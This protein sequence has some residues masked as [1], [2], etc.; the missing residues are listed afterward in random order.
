[1]ISRGEKSSFFRRCRKML[2]HLDGT[3]T[4]FQYPQ[5][6]RDTQNEDFA[7]GCWILPCPLPSLR[8]RGLR[9]SCR[10]GRGLFFGRRSSFG[11]SASSCCKAAVV[12]GLELMGP[13]IYPGPCTA[14]L[15][16]AARR[17]SFC[18]DVV[19]SHHSF[20]SSREWYYHVQILAQ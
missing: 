12:S 2:E 15:T 16:T 20:V 5:T 14:I 6:L 3:R 19:N 7:D 18:L 10:R 1:M 17:G 13:R 8:F 11:S 9:A 4:L